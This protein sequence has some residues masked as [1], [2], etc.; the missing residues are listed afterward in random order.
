MNTTQS[1]LLACLLLAGP[2]QVQAEFRIEGPATRVELIEL[3]TSEGCSSCPPAERWMNG[4]K[5]AP[6][7]WE[8]YIPMA[9]HVD[10]WDGL[11]WADRY[12]DAA[13]SERQR[14][15]AAHGRLSQVYTPGM[16]RAGREWRD[17]LRAAQPRA[18]SPTETGRLGLQQRGAASIDIRFTPAHQGP[19]PTVA[20]LAV[21]GFDLETEV[22]RGENAGRRLMHD[23]VVLG[24]AEAPLREGSASLELPRLKLAAP[25]MALVAWVTDDADPEPL[26]AAGG[27]WS[28]SDATTKP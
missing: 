5:S 16:L 1:S 24:V 9:W 3:Y 10:Y 17:W 6:G 14:N 20:H 4:L 21:L 27:W 28:P 2:W 19:A 15:Y 8:Q 22:P 7:L 13:Y 25:R 11:G 23:F 12:A 18:G 26:Q